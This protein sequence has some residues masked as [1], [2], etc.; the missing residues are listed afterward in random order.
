MK[1]DEVFME[2]KSSFQMT[3]GAIPLALIVAVPQGD[4]KWK[5]QARLNVTDLPAFG[6]AEDEWNSMAFFNGVLHSIDMLRAR[7][8]EYMLLEPKVREA[9]GQ[10]RESE[11][12]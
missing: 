6:A 7:F 2:D 5:L 9:L 8:Q 3:D 1:P 11:G 10:V 12:N 4:G